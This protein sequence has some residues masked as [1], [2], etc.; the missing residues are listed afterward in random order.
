MTTMAD[1]SDSLSRYRQL[2]AIL[3]SLLII[4]YIL[5][6]SSY[7]AARVVIGIDH[8]LSEL[9]TLELLGKFAQLV[10]FPL[11]ALL[12]AATGFYFGA[13]TPA[14]RNRS[15]RHQLIDFFLKV[16]TWVHNF[17]KFFEALITFGAYLFLLL[18]I[19]GGNYLLE[20]LLSRFWP[21]RQVLFDKLPI[22]Y[23]F[24]TIDT[25]AIVLFVSLG[26]FEV[27]RVLRPS[28]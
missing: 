22:S 27:I 2:V 14:D 26:C 1:F 15:D 19:I 18:L 16:R 12:G 3:L 24:D 9:P 20:A 13:K 17:G 4:L 11:T 25:A 21:A 8:P 10:G 7:F 23:I 5:A 28:G 6:L